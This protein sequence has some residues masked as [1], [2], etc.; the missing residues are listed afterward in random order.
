MV[1]GQNWPRSP[2]LEPVATFEG[3]GGWRGAATAPNSSSADTLSLLLALTSHTHLMAP[4]VPRPG[5]PGMV[6]CQNCT[7]PAVGW[8]RYGVYHNS[9]L[10]PQTQ[11]PVR[12]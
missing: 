8:N 12:V 7:I 2:K 5:I 1:C 4:M 6:F 9:F 11:L 10:T 3:V